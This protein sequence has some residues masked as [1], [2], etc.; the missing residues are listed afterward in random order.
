MGSLVLGAGGGSADALPP[1]PFA[2]R[3]RLQSTSSGGDDGP[4]TGPADNA[5]SFMN[6]PGPAV[7]SASSPA[8]PVWA[9]EDL[10]VVAAMMSPLVPELPLC[11]LAGPLAA[12]ELDALIW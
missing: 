9:P 1:N 11:A 7:S 6:L 5:P 12:T 10:E 2:T 4:Q 3:G 8:P